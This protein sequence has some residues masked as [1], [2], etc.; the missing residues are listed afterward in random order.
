MTKS[1]LLTINWNRENPLAQILPQPP[2]LSSSKADWNKIQLDYLYQPTH[3]TPEHLH[4]RHILA[5][6]SLEPDLIDREIIQ[7]KEKKC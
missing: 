6:L 4:T 2:L 7:G 3:E 5:V 1:H